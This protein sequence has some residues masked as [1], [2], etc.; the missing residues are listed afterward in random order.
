MCTV[1]SLPKWYHLSCI[2]VIIAS[3]P[4]HAISFP[5]GEMHT[6]VC[7]TMDALAQ[8][9]LNVCVCEEGEIVSLFSG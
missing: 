8:V 5:L 4:E 1:L 3:S 6:G 9:L 2:Y 7:L